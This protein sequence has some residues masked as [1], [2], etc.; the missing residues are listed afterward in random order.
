[1]GDNMFVL[2]IFYKHNQTI[3]ILNVNYNMLAITVIELFIF[4]LLT[5]RTYIHTS[6]LNDQS[7]TNFLQVLQI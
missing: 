7:I 5:D 2:L 3:L 4:K 1:M 6:L